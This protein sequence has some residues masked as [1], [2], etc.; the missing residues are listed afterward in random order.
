MGCE[1]SPFRIGKSHYSL[2]KIA[3]QATRLY[4]QCQF[5]I[6]IINFVKGHD[7]GSTKGKPVLGAPQQPV[8]SAPQRLLPL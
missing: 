5:F 7:M 2:G 6:I 4:Q 8:Q 3:K 1:K